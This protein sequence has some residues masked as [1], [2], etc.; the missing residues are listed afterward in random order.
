MNSTDKTMNKEYTRQ[1][2][3]A[4]LTFSVIAYLLFSFF[5][6]SLNVDIDWFSIVFVELYFLCFWLLCYLIKPNLKPNPLIVSYIIVLSIPLFFAL[7]YSQI[8]EIGSIDLNKNNVLVAKADRTKNY[9]YVLDAKKCKGSKYKGKTVIWGFLSNPLL[10]NEFK[11]QDYLGITDKKNEDINFYGGRKFSKK[12]ER[13]NN[14]ILASE[15]FLVSYTQ[16]NL[17]YPVTSLLFAM[18]SFRME[19]N[20]IHSISFEHRNKYNHAYTALNEKFNRDYFQRIYQK[21]KD[22][23]V[24]FSFSCLINALAFSGVI[25]WVKRKYLNK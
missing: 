9:V 3:I 13:D 18:T 12:Y 4:Y 17:H 23:Y 21:Q 16:H 11:Y 14:N 25:Y 19:K 7:N 2:G 8:Y 5:I 15:Y 20:I 1:K 6:A 24:L 22:R 10:C